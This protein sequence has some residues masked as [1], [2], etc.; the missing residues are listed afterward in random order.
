MVLPT[1]IRE[2]GLNRAYLQSPKMAA[3]LILKATVLFKK[4]FYSMTDVRKAS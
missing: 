1:L 4:R 3:E 2:T